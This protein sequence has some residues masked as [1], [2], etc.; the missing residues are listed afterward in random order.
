RGQDRLRVAQMRADRGVQ[1]RRPGSGVRRQRESRDLPGPA[2]EFAELCRGIVRLEIESGCEI[3]QHGSKR[4]GQ[5]GAAVVM[6]RLAQQ[7]E[8]IAGA[9]LAPCWRDGIRDALNLLREATH[10]DRRA[11]LPRSLAAM[12]ADFAA[13]LDLK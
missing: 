9:P 3:G 8:R 2:L 11:E 7:I 10:D 1:G 12:L 13:A 5:L 6:R 4:P